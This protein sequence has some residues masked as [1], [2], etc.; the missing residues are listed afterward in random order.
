MPPEDNDVAAVNLTPT[1]L[2]LLKL[3]I[4]Q[5]LQGGSPLAS[6]SPKQ[7]QPLPPGANP[8]QAIALTEDG[9]FVAFS[10]ANQIHLVHVPTGQ[11]VTK[12]AD[13]ALDTDQT[14]GIAHRDLIQSLAFNIDG[15][16][17]A[18]GGFREV[19]LWRRPR[20]VQ[21]WQVA[22]D[23]AATAVAVSH[24]RS[25]VAVAGTN[26]VVRLF[27]AADG[28]PGPTITGHQDQVT[29]LRFSSD[30]Q[31]LI[32]GSL[33]SSIRIW[34]TSDGKPLG[35]IES[36]APVHAIEIVDRV[37]PAD[38]QEPAV[39]WLVSGHADKL[40][41]VWDMPAAMPERMS[42]SPAKIA[43]TATS[44]NGQFM[45]L[46]GGDKNIRIVQLSSA[47][48]Q[49]F[50][51]EVATWG[52]DHEVTSLAFVPPGDAATEGIGQM[53]LTGAA[54][55]SLRLW[56]ISDK[57]Q[58]R[59]WS[60]EAKRVSA[61][62]VA[63]NGAVAASGLEDGTIGLWDLS[64]N[65][66]SAS[67][68][69]SNPAGEQD[70][71][72]EADAPLRKLEGNQQPIT[73]IAFAADGQFVFTAAADGSLRGYNTQ[74]GQQTFAT[75][76]GA[77]IHD[78]VI[79]PN[80]Q[81]LA[82]AGENAVVRLWQT[83][84]GGYGPNQLTGLPG[85]ARGVAFSVDGTKVIA[86]ATGEMSATHV[87][88][89]QS[90]DLLQR[91]TAAPGAMVDCV[92]VPSAMERNDERET[93]ATLV[94]VS[95]TGVYRWTATA[96]RKLAGHSQTVTSLAVD[97]ERQQH[98]YSGSLDGT[99]RRWNL[100]NGQS[101]QQINHGGP[102]TSIA[103]SPDGQRI[104]S[105]S[106]NR[107]ALL[108]RTNGQ[109][110]AE[111]RGDVRSKIRQLRAQQQLT[112]VNA[113]LSTAKRLVDEAEKD[114]PKK[115]EAEKKLSESLAA[116]NKEVDEKQKALDEAVAKKIAAEREAIAASTAAKTA[117]AD[118]EQ[119]ELLAK[120]A[121]M[122]MQDAQT[123]INQLQRLVSDSPNNEQIQK[124]L[125][126]AQQDLAACQKES[127][128]RTAA[129]KAPTEKAQEMASAANKAAQKV[130]EVQKPFSDA[131][132]ALKTSQSKQ[133]LLSQQQAL[134][135]FELQRAKDLIPLR[136]EALLRAEAAKSEAEKQV[137]EANE[138]AKES[139]QP[140]RSIAF[141]PDGKVLATSG[142]FL[143]FHTWDGLSG[144]PLAAFAGHAAATPEIAFLDDQT[145]VSAS[146]D[147][148]C[149]RWEVNP[150]WMLERTIGSAE[151]PTV[152]THRATAVD[153]SRDST[154][155][156]VAGGIP[157]R[158]G[159][160]QVFDVADG[161]RVLYLPEAHDDVIY[162]ARFSPD[163]K[164]IA[165][166]GADKYLRTFDVE[167]G[168][169]LRRFEGHT[170]YVLGVAWKGDSETIATASADNTIKFWEAE[171]GDQRRT[172]SQQ[173][174]KH[175][176]AIQF[177]GDANNV[178]SSSGDKR[179]RIHRGDNGGI[180]RNFNPVK[181]WLHCVAI[182]PDNQIAA[183]GDASGTVTIWNATNGQVLHT[184]ASEPSQ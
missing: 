7:W 174:T 135:A 167:T 60:G 47:K 179:V 125:E 16:L 79:S 134:A 89:L 107:N 106:E 159:E 88:D 76:H 93:I 83:N 140:I 20:D 172:I 17:L 38:Q 49:P 66:T 94:T 58:V 50:G 156:L 183:A 109:R 123:K 55:G 150:S 2:G 80:G 48:D 46:L 98:V 5:G 86:C 161:S 115:T 113:R 141:S 31:Q 147:M 117:I 15:D 103:V 59:Q 104:A 85:P 61:L 146:A 97:P 114:L 26:G 44:H 95:D 102:V 151:D 90:G 21:Q 30:D 165:S 162:A 184:I 87:F 144:E 154:Q 18:S 136:K 82:T 10:R 71:D 128:E 77:A 182:T 129:V 149:R 54:D 92:T 121:A 126:S 52:F 9:Q 145:I 81:V 39:P 35:M 62:A 74:T 166:A 84:G 99:I 158:S 132:A 37:K 119:S 180:L 142:Q 27:R 178:I 101:V 32:T 45:A 171:T 70:P 118:Q 36:P 124:M 173:L 155:L 29:S 25:L 40:L 13:S 131:A 65:A 12:L 100:D 57:R 130:N 164:R 6:L 153:F 1:E 91:F 33:D 139:E 105:A 43:L 176:T 24:D 63:E 152:I 127:Q 68:D 137:A 133:N 22:V 175:M 116:A 78:L 168:K 11:L 23:D 41:R 51:T 122:A 56:N 181:S 170:D 4:D 163:G 148:S 34:N 143:S 111:M 157:S 120:N 64:E 177:V 14:T 112:S 53:L 96:G 75:S 19:K 67:T 110:I 28:Q 73:A 72:D 42:T 138:V 108:F 160:L 8:V 3:W 69:E 169:Q